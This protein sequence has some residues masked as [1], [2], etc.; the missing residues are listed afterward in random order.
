MSTGNPQ[1]KIETPHGNILISLNADVAPLHTQ[2]FIK[3]A[4]EGFFDKTTF[5]RVI[6]KFMIQGGDPNSKTNEK[7]SHGLGGPN[8]TIPAEIKLQNKRGTVAAARK[9]DAVNPKRESSGSQFYINVADNGFLDGQYTV[10]GEV[11]EGMDVADLIAGVAKDQRD[12]PVERIEMKV[13]VV[14]QVP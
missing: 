10:F 1:V 12:N 3:L 13:T 11:L 2:N 14:P 6:P 5:H 4:T 7:S 8:Y 9:G